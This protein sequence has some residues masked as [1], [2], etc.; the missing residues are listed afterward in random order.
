[1]GIVQIKNCD[2][3]YDFPS[4]YPHFL[5]YPPLALFLNFHHHLIPLPH[6]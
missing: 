2:R 3:Y 6:C 1:M 5:R 4:A